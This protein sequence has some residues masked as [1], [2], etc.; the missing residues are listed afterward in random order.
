MPFRDKT[1]DYVIAF[2]VLEHI[3]RPELFL[4]ELMRV[5]KAGYIETPNVIFEH[6]VPYDIHCLEV[7]NLG[8][9]LFI[10]KKAAPV[11][12]PFIGKLNI[13]SRSARWNDFFYGNPEYFHVRYHWTDRIEFDI[14]NPE[15]SCSWYMRHATQFDRTDE[16]SSKI[17]G[18]GLRGVATRA[19]RKFYALRRPPA[20]L[21][22][23]LVCP[24][25]RSAPT[26]EGETF[27]CVR[28]RKRYAGRPWPVFV[29]PVDDAMTNNMDSM[30]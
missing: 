30:T 5:A 6:L 16:P 14:A 28:C 17:G 22:S 10:R 29:E 24:D 8:D 21:P 15:E 23:L 12:D 27:H 25:C 7:M 26:D 18:K 1:F 9:R 4:E 11:S 2:H 20:D 3:P 13:V 19:V